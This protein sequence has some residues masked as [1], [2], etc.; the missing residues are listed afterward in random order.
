MRMP[1]RIEPISDF[2]PKQP[3]NERRGIVALEFLLVLPTLIL[4]GLLLY[5][6]VIIV[7]AEQQL[8]LAVNRGARVGAIGGDDAQI[9]Q[10]VI[11]S[12]PPGS[13]IKAYLTALPLVPP[14][15]PPI[16]PAQ[17]TAIP[18]TRTP[19]PGLNGT[20]T[21][22]IDIPI[23]VVLPKWMCANTRLKSQSVVLVQ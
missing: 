8:L 19:T 21:V 3:Q 18:V 11:D 2:A 16:L 12:L 4:L 5:N 15:P 14:T 22:A 23:C 1:Q 7:L 20:V 6:L 10:T 17:S 9:R 13:P